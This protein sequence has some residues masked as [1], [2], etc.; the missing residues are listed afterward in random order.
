MFAEPV[1]NTRFLPD[2]ARVTIPFDGSY[3]GFEAS[4]LKKWIDL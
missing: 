1:Q 4:P 2:A 3:P